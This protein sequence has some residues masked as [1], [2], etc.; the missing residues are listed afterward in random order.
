MAPDLF[1]DHSASHYPN[2][3]AD[4][5]QIRLIV[6]A[7]GAPE[8]PIH[9]T[10]RVVSLDDED[11]SYE[12][13]SY[14]W[15]DAAGTEPIWVDGKAASVT[16]SLFGALEQLRHVDGDSTLWI[17]AI[18]INQGDSAEKTRQVDMMRRIYSQCRQCNIWLGPLG[19][20]SLEDA[21]LAI[22]MVAWMAGENVGPPAFLHDASQRR[23]AAD[24]LTVL[25]TRPWWTRIWTVQEVILPPRSY[26]HWGPCRLPWDLLERASDAVM[27]DGPIKPPPDLRRY[28]PDFRPSGALDHL[29]ARVRGLRLTVNEHPLY[30][31][32]RWRCREATD[33][34]DKVYALLGMRRDVR[35]PSV[36]SCDYTV[37]VRTLFT[38]VTVDLINICADL[39]PLIGRR[40]AR[41]ALPGLPSWVVDWSGSLPG[42]GA[43][44]FWA[45]QA[46][47]TGRGY[48]ADRGTFGVG[49]GLRLADE[50]TLLLAGLYVDRIAVVEQWSQGQAGR[51]QEIVMGR[52]GRWGDLITRFQ[53]FGADTGHAVELPGD[54]MQ[55][56][57]GVLTGR[58][59]PGDPGDGEAY[60]DGWSKDMLRDQALF[61]TRGGRFGLGPLNAQPGQQL[62]IV[63]GCRLP[64]LL[65]MWPSGSNG[66][67][68]DESSCR[69]FT[70]VSECFVYGMMK[71][72]AVEGRGDEQVDI[73]LH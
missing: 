17:D 6:L 65:D 67:D 29:P 62:W 48:C 54:W 64:V 35:L 33:P 22:D 72:E 8:S 42:Q 34:R 41:S 5:A 40:G 4:S 28:R 55:A 44:D 21:K 46:R 69:D 56:F 57:L 36:P 58:L 49:D 16:R 39:D 18:C 13:L 2:L 23:R 25:L 30:L 10:Y 73:R 60:M 37:K 20:T 9:C 38:R 45:H 27:G 51:S 61:I 19:Q 7:R 53:R 3:D 63:G 50:R 70:W 52:A 1:D 12:T 24:V 11:L 31:F 26:I 43:E 66:E 47:W 14:V 71:G 68:G 32:Y 59:V 15:K